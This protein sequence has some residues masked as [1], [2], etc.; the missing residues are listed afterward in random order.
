MALTVAGELTT[1]VDAAAI[2]LRSISESAAAAKRSQSVWSIKEILG[3]LVDSA[4]NNHQRFVRAQLT[5]P[6]E[7]PGYEQDAWVRVEDHQ[8]RPWPEL[9]EFWVLYNRYLSHVIERIP[10]SSLD[11]SCRIGADEPVTLRFL[12]EDYLRH[13]RHHLN[14]IR[15]RRT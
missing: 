13:L 10:D 14:Q 12:A 5:N 9:V 3:H 1:A 11:V 4:S 2:E 8:S 7:L 6:L 15:E